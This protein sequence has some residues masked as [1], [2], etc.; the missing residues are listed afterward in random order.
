MVVQLY[1]SLHINTESETDT[2][3]F[4]HFGFKIEELRIQEKNDNA[5]NER[6]ENRKK[7][8]KENSKNENNIV[9]K[10]RI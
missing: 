10:E 1:C 5:E 4:D 3:C 2:S 8:K 6:I 7:E 9:M